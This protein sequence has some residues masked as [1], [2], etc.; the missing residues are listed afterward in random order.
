MFEV[1]QEV[2]PFKLSFDMFL[3]SFINLKLLLLI[4][5][6]L[7]ISFWFYIVSRSLKIRCSQIK[8]PFF[9][10]EGTKGNNAAEQRTCYVVLE[11]N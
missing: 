11:C 7:D 1:K 3:R 10:S 2:P 9:S 4:P 6:S 8:S 5:H